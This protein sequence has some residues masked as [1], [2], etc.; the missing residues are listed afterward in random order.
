M[1]TADTTTKPSVG[2]RR[3]SK[4]R[5]TSADH[6]RRVCVTGALVVCQDLSAISAAMHRA[7]SVRPGENQGV[8]ARGPDNVSSSSCRVCPGSATDRDA[9]YQWLVSVVGLHRTLSKRP[10]AWW[11]RPAALMDG[12]IPGGGDGG[13]DG[14]LDGGLDGA[15]DSSIPEG[16][17]DVGIDGSNEADGDGGAPGSLEWVSSPGGGLL[18]LGG[19][20]TP[21]RGGMGVRSALGRFGPRAPLG[22]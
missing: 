19:Q 21:E 10:Y 5:V 12:G 8:P 6:M 16:S 4:T 18:H 13:M 14:G 9:G 7:S 17:P 3:Q 11:C 20:T 1:R 15:R 2:H 22:R